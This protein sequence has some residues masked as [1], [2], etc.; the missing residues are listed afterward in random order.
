MGLVQALTRLRSCRD[1]RYH[2]HMKERGLIW[3]LEAGGLLAVIA[4]AMYAIFPDD[5]TQAAACAFPFY[6]C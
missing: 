5:I 1:Y 2:A 3:W 4:V 6:G